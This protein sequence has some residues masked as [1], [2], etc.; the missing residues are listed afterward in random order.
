MKQGYLIAASVAVL[1]STAGGAFAA[2]AY[3]IDP[4]HAWVTFSINHAGWAK[5]SG[6][7]KAVSGDIVFDKND[8]TKSSVTV[9]LEAASIDTNFADR[10]RDLNSPDFLNVA[11]FPAITFKSTSVTKTGDKTGQVTGSLTIIGV[12][13]PV[14]LDVEWK[15]E[16][17][18]PW[19][20]SVIKTGFSAAAVVKPADYGMAKVAAFGLGPDI[21]V[22]I[23]V[24]A[25][26]Q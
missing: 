22:S 16:R 11:E 26:K 18:L 6:I 9:Q 3:K 20:A 23:E 8:V 7:F 24:E 2:D 19:D 17:P 5:A 21:V 13:K 10:D 1:L 15:A 14:T 25:I 12:T 4:Q